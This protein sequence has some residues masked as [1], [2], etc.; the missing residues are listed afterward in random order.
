MHTCILSHSVV[1]SSLHPMDYS[2]P[3]SSVHGII[4]ERIPEWVAFP[5]PG[6]LP[7]P[8]SLAKTRKDMW[9]P[10]EISFDMNLEVEFK[11]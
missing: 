1:S 7:S 2:L 9:L 8:I 6:D 4:L 10:E 11:M 5:S 3:G